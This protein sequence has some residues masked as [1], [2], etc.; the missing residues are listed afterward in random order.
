MKLLDIIFE[1]ENKEKLIKKYRTIYKGLKRGVIG[2]GHFGK[3][4]YVLPDE[5]DLQFDIHDEA[6]I[7][8]GGHKSDN[9]IKFYY[10]HDNDGEYKPYDLNPT[11]YQLNVRKIEKKKFDPFGM[12]LYYDEGPYLNE[13]IDTSNDDRLIKK[14]KTINKTLRKGT[15]IIPV[16]EGRES[17]DT[18]FRYEVPEKCDVYITGGVPYVKF[19]F[20]GDGSEPI[21]VRFPLKVWKVEE[22]RDVL[23]NTHMTNRDFADIEDNLDNSFLSSI[24]NNVYNYVKKRYREFEVFLDL[25]IYLNHDYNRRLNEDED[26]SKKKVKAVFK[27]FK[28]GL[29]YTGQNGS[30]LYYELPDEYKILEHGVIP[31]NDQEVLFIQVGRETEDNCIKFFRK[32]KEDENEMVRQDA[33][34]DMYENYKHI[35][36][37]KLRPFNMRIIFKTR[38][39]KW[40]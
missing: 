1:D 39:G 40:K 35:L 14:A 5:Y 27:A 34:N 37:L 12:V 2:R 33:T 8:V 19:K 25:A 28:K 4:V 38:N 18:K 22:G 36:N 6:F 29:L 21:G 13:S 7:K 11:E 16:R 30:K 3:I 10:V 31:D 20:D 23:L 24:F 26:K 17:V 15:M 9:G 32:S